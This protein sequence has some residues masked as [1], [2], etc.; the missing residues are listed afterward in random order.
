[1]STGVTTKQLL[2][3]R[4]W[5][6]GQHP[7]TLDC[8]MIQRKQPVSSHRWNVGT[9]PDLAF[10]GFGQ[11]KRLPDRHVLGKFLR[12]QH[13]PSHITP[14][15][16][17]VPSH[18]DPVKRWNFRKADWKRL[19]LLTCESIERLPPPDTLNIER[20]YQDFCESVLSAAKQCIPRGR[21]KNYV[22]CWYKECETLYRSFIQAPVGTESDRAASSLLSWQEQKWQEGCEEAV[23]SIDFSHSSRKAW[24]TINK[25]TGRSGH[26]SRLC[27]ILA[28]S[29]ALQLVTNGP[30][31]TGDGDSTRLINKDMSNLWKVPTP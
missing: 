2:T 11:D 20:A 23:N 12:S 18:S 16:L 29:I 31:K 25:L 27:P 10:G 4:A 19:C 5:T 30:H 7:T 8:R 13:R 1:M 22:S 21:R 3:V 15:R 26:F 24:R 14:P 6:P 17:K 9:N 28:N